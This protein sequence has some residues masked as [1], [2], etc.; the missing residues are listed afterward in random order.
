MIRD[1]QL[2]VVYSLLKPALR[3]AA[4][5]GVPMRTVSELVRLGYYEVLARDGASAESIAEQLG[6]SSRHVRSLA[7]RLRSD[8]FS[9]ETRIG[10]TREIEDRVAAKSP[11]ERE[12]RRSLGSYP[13]DAVTEAVE[14]LLRDRRIERDERGNLKTGHRYVVLASDQL[15]Q[16]VDAL[17]HFLDGVYRA[18]L[19][20]LIHDER[21]TAM[22]K[23]ITFT[24]RAEELHAYLQRLEGDLRRE[25][26]NLEESAAFSGAHARR[27]T[28]GLSVSALEDRP[29]D[30]SE[31]IAAP[32]PPGTASRG[33]G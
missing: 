14:N 25:L 30:A 12:L 20:R 27:Y 7:R 10:L 23:T 6:Q 5:F 15:P 31:P 28:L 2:R 17:N 33:R 8:F 22:I 1:K 26:A 9:A 3:M 4:R 19:E 11:T 13:T 24:A 16:R 29:A 21:R 18:V 32:V